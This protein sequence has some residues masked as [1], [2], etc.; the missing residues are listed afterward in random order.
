MATNDTPVEW[1]RFRDIVF[2]TGA[3]ARKGEHQW[4]RKNAIERGLDPDVVAPL[5]HKIGA[6]PV[7]PFERGKKLPN[8]SCSKCRICLDKPKVV[9]YT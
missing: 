3:T 5:I 4:R 9:E 7:C 2:R 6:A 8:F 1:L